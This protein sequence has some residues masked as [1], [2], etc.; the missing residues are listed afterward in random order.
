MADGGGGGL[1]V[2][3]LG[4]LLVAAERTFLRARLGWVIL[5]VSQL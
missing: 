3:G 2:V 4:G 1:E 5:S